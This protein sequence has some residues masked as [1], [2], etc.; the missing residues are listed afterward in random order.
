M[1]ASDS[2]KNFIKNS[3]D[4]AAKIFLIGLLLV[5]SYNIIKPFVLPVVWAIIIAVAFGPFIDKVTKWLGGRRK[6]A[7]VGFSLVA[8][9][10][11]VVPV[12]LLASSSLEVVQYVAEDLKDNKVDFIQEAPEKVEEIPVVGKKVSEIWN[13]AATDLKGAIVATAPLAQ[14]AATKLVAS[15]GS[16]LGGIVQFVIS[17]IIAGVLMINPAKGFAIT[18]KVARSFDANRGEEFTKLT[19]ATIRGVMTGVIGVAVIQAVLGTIGMVVMGIPAAGVWGVLILICAIV[20][21]PP[22]IILG[23]IAAYGFAAYDTTPA[24]IFLIWAFLVS[25]SDGVL[26]PVLM[27]RGVDTPMLVI[28]LGAIGGMMMSGIVGLFVGAV[29]LSI[30]YA[31]FMAWVNEKAGDTPEQASG[32]E[33]L[34]EEAS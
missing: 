26:K 7:C 14:D 30:T 13:M 1:N 4:V 21:L 33:E 18:S 8:V 29:V 11:L 6:M 32:D 10:V 24:I 25:A 15:I 20:Q 5:L 9:A 34:Q 22:I 27:A 16:G 2:D 17:F 12:W 28:L 23:P 31:I 19:V 3:I